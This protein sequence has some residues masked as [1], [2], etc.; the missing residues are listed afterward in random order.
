MQVEDEFKLLKTL[1][2]FVEMIFDH[3]RHR[4]QLALLMQLADITGNQ[5]SAFLGVC[6]NNVKIT[7]LP[8]LQRGKFPQRL[9]EIAFKNTKGYLGEKE[10]FVFL[11][12][13]LLSYGII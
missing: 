1:H 13:T 6:Y 5:P 7:L 3:E 12:V 8:D 11:S 4:V 9:I 10:T 2:F